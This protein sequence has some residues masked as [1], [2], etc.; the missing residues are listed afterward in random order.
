MCL[1]LEN[2]NVDPE[3]LCS[4]PGPSNAKLIEVRLA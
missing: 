3:A 4:I 1:Q 2:L